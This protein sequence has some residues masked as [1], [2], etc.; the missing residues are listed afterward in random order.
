M[1]T[2]R[3][4][5]L[6]GLFVL[7]A[8]WVLQAQTVQDMESKLAPAALALRDALTQKNPD[9]KELTIATVPL[10]D[11]EQNV[12]KL[13]VVVAQIVERQLIAA[14]PEWLRVQSRLN[15]ASVMDEQKLWI[16]D[17][18]KKS[19]K[20]NSAPAGFLEKADFLVV[21]TVTPG[22]EQVT[23]ELRLIGT[24]NGNVLTAQSVSLPT[25][26]AIREL[27]KYMIR[28]E[29]RE[30]V[31]IAPVNN[32]TLTVTAQREGVAG[33]RVKEWVV[34]EGETLK[35]GSDQFN[36]RFAVDADATTYVFLFG[37]D[38]QTALLFPCEDW[39][40]QFERTF[41]RK[42]KTRDNF[43]RADM[44]YIVPGTDTANQPRYFR[45]DTTPGNNT[46]Y[47]CA[48]RAEIRNYREIS[49]RLTQAGSEEARL[50][51]L[52]DTFKIDCV[53]VFS[54]KQDSGK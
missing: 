35:G 32:I 34:K 29:G 12:R 18:V 21:G 30:A 22:N 38:Q 39:E 20:E 19:S 46:L 17:L 24:R 6:I 37:S 53:K 23:I 8:A 52:T 36:V 25:T 54:F 44:D 47:V 42:A 14:K 50:K 5:I 51:V 10:V 1:N 27:F 40:A 9:G 11:T 7:A 13:G 31:D 2:R 28:K 3:M 45:L 41:G 43:C 26:P 49:D 4:H 48:N 15:L 33:A 16:T